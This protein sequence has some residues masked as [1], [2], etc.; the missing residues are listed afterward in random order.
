M[1]MSILKSKQTSRL[2]LDSFR[3]TAAA[4]NIKDQVQMITGGA[5]AGCHIVAAKL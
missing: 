3:A 2:S 4:A 1:N 5:L